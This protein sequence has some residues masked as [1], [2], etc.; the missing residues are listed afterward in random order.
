MHLFFYFIFVQF[1]H[2]LV[3]DFGVVVHYGAA[4][5]YMNFST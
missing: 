1:L 4:I 5:M 3:L 2:F